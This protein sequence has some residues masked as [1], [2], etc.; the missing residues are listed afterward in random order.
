M[1][2]PHIYAIAALSRKIAL[3]QLLATG[4]T[5]L[6]AYNCYLS[7]S[8]PV[9]GLHWGYHS[10]FAAYGLATAARCFMYE[11]CTVSSMTLLPDGKRLLIQ[12][13]GLFPVSREV[14]IKSL[15]SRWEKNKVYISAPFKGFF[16]LHL[17][18]PALLPTTVQIP[19]LE[20]LRKVLEGTEVKN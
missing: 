12:T 2:P 3:K 7:V 10:L 13:S 5:S 15:A 6:C 20:L 4:F 18:P 17:Q 8:F 11:S 9:F 16:V 1:N 19:D 14:H